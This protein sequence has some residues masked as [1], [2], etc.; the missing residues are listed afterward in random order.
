[1]ATLSLALPVAP[2]EGTD[3]PALMKG[4]TTE[5][6]PAVSPAAAL[7][8][9]L[10]ASQ[11]FAGVSP[12]SF[13]AL[14]LALVAGS[15]FVRRDDTDTSVPITVVSTE[16]LPAGKRECRTWRVTEDAATG[17]FSP[18]CRKWVA[19]ADGSTT[20]NQVLE[21]RSVKLVEEGKVCNAWH[22][23]A[24]DGYVE[25]I[26]GRVKPEPPL[27]AVTM[28]ADDTTAP[29]QDAN[30]L[31][32]IGREPV[33]TREAQGLGLKSAPIGP[34][35]VP[36][37]VSCEAMPC[38][39]L[40]AGTVPGVNCD[41]SDEFPDPLNVGPVIERG[42]DP[43][44][45]GPVT[46]PPHVSCE[47]TSCSHACVGTVPGVNCDP[48]NVFAY[49]LGVG[50]VVSRA[51]DPAPVHDSAN[52]VVPAGFDLMPPHVSCHAMPCSRLCAGT[53][54]GVH[55]DP[56]DE[57][58]YPLGIGPVIPPRDV[59]AT[60]YDPA[61]N[62]GPV[63]LPSV[64]PLDQLVDGIKKDGE[65]VVKAA[66]EPLRFVGLAAGPVV[67]E[68]KDMVVAGREKLAQSLAS[69]RDVVPDP[70]V[71]GFGP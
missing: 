28:P 46:M 50:P 32:F 63:G 11:A 34:V 43:A 18:S 22:V 8:P 65:D 45:V 35:G 40:C 2:R 68:A 67:Q 41:T 38:S 51:D 24:H 71:K 69:T 49:P 21:L 60:V 31:N 7:A 4:D 6:L 52:Y 19:D 61:A 30:F 20:D 56:R 42:D 64:A 26:C 53:V 59:P 62:V 37:H 57:F 33:V 47:A 1:M 13:P 15:P 17:V 54:P 55:C 58:S 5:T 66:K 44:P 36:P 23:E 10:A 29:P 3:L 16:I 14:P 48:A 27:P 25:P 12:G 70:I 9:L 39:R